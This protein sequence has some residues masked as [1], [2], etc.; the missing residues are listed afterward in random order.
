MT[1]FLPNGPNGAQSTLLGATTPRAVRWKKA[2]EDF[3]ANRASRRAARHTRNEQ[4]T[5]QNTGRDTQR[6]AAGVTAGAVGDTFGE[7]EELEAD[8]DDDHQVPEP[9]IPAGEAPPNSKALEDAQAIYGFIK[10][11][12]PAAQHLFLSVM[13][14]MKGSSPAGPGASVAPAPP[15]PER[16]ATLPRIFN[17]AAVQPARMEE[18]A[19]RPPFSPRILELAMGGIY[20]ERSMFTN[21]RIRD[22]FVNQSDPKY[23]PKKRT[24]VNDEGK[25]VNVYTLDPSI[26]EDETTMS[27]IRFDEA[28]ANYRRWFMEHAPV[29]AAMQLEAYDNHRQRCRDVVLVDEKDFVM[30]QRWCRSWMQRQTWCPTVWNEAIYHKEFE[31]SRARYFE[32]KVASQMAELERHAQRPTREHDRNENSSS[33]ARSTYPERTSSSSYPERPSPYSRE[34]PDREQRSFRKDTTN[35]LCL[36][37]GESGHMA[38]ECRAPRTAKGGPIK[39]FV[40]GGKVFWV[41]DPKTQV[42]VGWNLHGSCEARN[43]NL[44][45]HACTLC[46]TTKHHAASGKC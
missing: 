25:T 7:D 1:N 43:A 45:C 22:M 40:E 26:F 6:K 5:R 21:E 33:R 39:I 16:P 32:N 37:C 23:Q 9:P 4:K 34:K 38:R 15:T 12:D 35:A 20:L 24:I 46:G 31:T 36:K 8:S 10:D 30:V 18:N 13:A 42:C 29:E 11:L 2:Q 19:D 44:H 28:H 17:A 14:G 41:S 27:H 3:L